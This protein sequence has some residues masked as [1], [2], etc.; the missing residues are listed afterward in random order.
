MD[1]IFYLIERFSLEQ[2]YVLDL[3]FGGVV[4]QQ[5]LISNRRCIALCRD[6]LEAMTLMTKCSQILEDN[7]QI[8]EWCGAQVSLLEKQIIEF[9][10]AE[11]DAL[12]NIEVDEQPSGDEED[13]EEENEKTEDSDSSA[14]DEEVII[15]DDPFK[16]QSSVARQNNGDKENEKENQQKSGGDEEQEKIGAEECNKNNDKVKDKEESIHACQ[17]NDKKGN[18]DTDESSKIGSLET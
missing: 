4:L 15:V 5:S 2:N 11:R 9:N 10:D 3:F 7:P 17:S 6:D 1:F 14:K 12:D 8:Q 16:S 13:E 18:D